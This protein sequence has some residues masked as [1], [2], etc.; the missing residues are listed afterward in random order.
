ML[1]T[2]T[3]Q[4]EVSCDAYN[5]YASLTIVLA[6]LERKLQLNRKQICN[7]ILNYSITHNLYNATKGYN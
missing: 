5:K 1:K 4:N 6:A 2:K 3:R 7:L